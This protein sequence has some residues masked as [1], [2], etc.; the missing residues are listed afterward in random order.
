MALDL[1]SLVSLTLGF[2]V[3]RFQRLSMVGLN[4]MARILTRSADAGNVQ[5]FGVAADG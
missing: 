5:F 1:L 2:V 4:R 3:E